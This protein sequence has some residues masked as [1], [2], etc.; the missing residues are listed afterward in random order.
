MTYEAGIYAW[1]S[2][3]RTLRQTMVPQP[4]PV[5]VVP[6]MYVGCLPFDSI[7]LASLECFF[8]AL[9]L[10][11][12][13]QWISNLPASSWPKPLNSS[14]RSQFSPSTK[15]QQIFSYQM[16]ER[17]DNRTNFSSYYAACAPNECTYTFQGRNNFAY[18][19]ITIIGAFGGLIVVIRILASLSVQFYRRIEIFCRIRNEM[20]DVSNQN[21]AGII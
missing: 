18:I 4:P 8:D 13:S 19:L 10:N 6:G 7:N 17:W 9:C 11:S 5:F 21:G 3:L 12:T 20:T 2:D 1:A 16:V 14:V 15:I